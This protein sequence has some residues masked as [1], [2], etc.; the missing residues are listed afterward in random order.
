MENLL[1]NLDRVLICSDPCYSKILTILLNEIGVGQIQSLA[2]G[3]DLS[4]TLT[5]FQPDF[6]FIDIDWGTNP[7]TTL[8]MAQHIHGNRCDTPVVFLLS[9]FKGELA[10]DIRALPCCT[11]M[12]KDFSRLSL[13]KTIQYALSHKENALLSRSIKV[14]AAQKD[15]PTIQASVSPS[16]LFFKV[17]DKFKRISK[18]KIAFFFAENKMTYARVGHRNFPMNIQ[19]KTLEE[20][21]SP[22]FL[23]CHKKYLVNVERIDSIIMKEGKIRIED[24][25]LPIGYVYRK[26]FF[27]SLQLM[28]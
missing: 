23:R 21:L 19:L 5:K 27:E 15:L 14:S 3:K 6:C 26:P 10:K 13:L 25:L 2:K 9:N 16:T 11:V 1:S 28:R 8:K 4:N 7:A 17:G 12:T 22:T 24:E 18:D 20:K